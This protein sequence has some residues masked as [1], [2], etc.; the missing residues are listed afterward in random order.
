[1]IDLLKLK[2]EMAQEK[3]KE[4]RDNFCEF[5]FNHCDKVNYTGKNDDGLEWFIENIIS[6]AIDRAADLCKQEEERSH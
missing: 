6:S 3:R 2:V 5:S 4:F 1:M